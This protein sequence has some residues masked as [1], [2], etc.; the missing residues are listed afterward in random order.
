MCLQAK[1]DAESKT[2][3]GDID[4]NICNDNGTSDANGAIAIFPRLGT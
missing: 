4:V 3:A 2:D 1:I